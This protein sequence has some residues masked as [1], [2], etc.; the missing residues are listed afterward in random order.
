[1]KQHIVLVILLGVALL[2]G[3]CEKKGPE[4]KTFVPKV[5]VAIVQQ[6][7]SLLQK[8]FSGI[9]KEAEEVNLAFRV[10]GPIEKIYVKE[11]DY[12]KE[13]QLIAEM[14]TRDYQIQLDA[15]QAQYDQVIAEVGR[16]K[17]LH[18]K[19]SIADN[20]F[21]KAVSGEKMVSAKLRHAK[22]QLHD[23]KIFAPFSGYI[24]KVNFENG[25]MVNHG[26]TIAT[27]IN[28]STYQVDVDIPASLFVLKEEFVSFGC[29]QHMV[30]DSLLPLKLVSYNKKADNNQLYR[31]HFQL[32]PKA[33]ERLA[34]GMNVEV[35]IVYENS[36][37]HPNYIPLT[38][39]TYEGGQAY[40]FVLDEESSM[41]SKREITTNGL[42]KRGYIR[43]IDGLDVNEIIV[44]AGV[45][46]LVEGQHVKRLQANAHTNVGGLL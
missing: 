32:D 25:E 40:V 37:A 44:V 45:G 23:T 1:M 12:V 30:N 4:A 11:G 18:K 10:A 20:D 36:H 7:S 29:R 42:Y 2:F 19:E 5:K 3:A 35:E 43:L 15:A 21:D 46:S 39:I 9:I 28:V 38:A 26:M 16:V 6:A 13:G 17:E 14:D 41:V 24:Q 33:E 31:L 34:P 22:D 8:E 27:L